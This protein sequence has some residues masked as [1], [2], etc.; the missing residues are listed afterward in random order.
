MNN[1]NNK[2]NINN[3][4]NIMLK[5]LLLNIGLISNNAISAPLDLIQ[6]I[7]ENYSYEIDSQGYWKQWASDE[8]GRTSVVER[9]PASNTTPGG[10][11]SFTM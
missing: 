7:N 2:N 3:I 8:A 5:V 6:N 11:Y 4:N 1:K 9:T 10:G